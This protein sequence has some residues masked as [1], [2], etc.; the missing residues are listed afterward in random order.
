MRKLNIKGQRFGRLTA[1]SCTG[2]KQNGNYMWRCLCDCG[3]EVVVKADHLR[4]GDTQ[5]CGCINIGRQKGIPKKHGFACNGKHERLYDVWLSMRT[6]CENPKHVH[7]PNYGG[8]GIK[9]CP[10][11][12]DFVVFKEWALANGYDKTAPRGK[13]TIDRIDNDGDYCPENCRWADMKTQCRNRRN[14]HLKRSCGHPRAVH[15]GG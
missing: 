3:K 2:E 10:E 4:R 11:W 12:H 1:I 15:K 5:S 7:Y 14:S 8:R 13:C 6:R 9:V